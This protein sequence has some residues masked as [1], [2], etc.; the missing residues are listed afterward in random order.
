MCARMTTCMAMA[1]GLFW[2]PVGLAEDVL[3]RDDF[4]DGLSSKWQAVGLRKED[5][6]IREGGLE[7]RVQP[8]KLRRDTP[9]LKVVLPIT[10]SDT[11]IASVEVTILDEFTE[12]E[13]FV[14][15]FFTDERGMDFGGQKQL[16][17][18][19][20]VFSPGKYDFIGKPGEEGDPAKYAVKYWPAD[21]DAGPLRI[22]VREHYAHFQ[23]GPSSEGKYLNLFQSAIGENQK[24][25]GF[26]LVAAG[27][28]SDAV[29]WVRF[30]TFRV[31]R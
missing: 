15:L 18:G 11:V 4:D 21:N 26:S 29:H 10:S 24:E 22:I 7:L 23:V 20:L 17:R 25:R 28:P 14:G 6:R 1:V 13:E 2:S 12:P 19:R 30:D 27:G 3:F 9:M 31:T 5:Y 16:I 8:G